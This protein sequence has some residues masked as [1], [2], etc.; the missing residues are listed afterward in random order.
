MD[1]AGFLIIGAGLNAMLGVLIGTFTGLYA[2]AQQ[3]TT[4]AD[5]QSE[6]RRQACFK[7]MAGAQIVN[8]SV[9][10]ALTT[11]LFLLLYGRRGFLPAGWL[12]FGILAAPRLV[13]LYDAARI[14]VTRDRIPWRF[15]GSFIRDESLR[16]QPPHSSGAPPR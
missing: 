12:L 13:L 14:Y 5:G 4:W 1:Q 16:A 6:S 10:L 7:A 11:A 8:Q 15:S 2:V 9:L 3:G